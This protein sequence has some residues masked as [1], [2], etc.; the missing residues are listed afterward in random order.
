[1]RYAILLAAVCIVACTVEMKAYR[2]FADVTPVTYRVDAAPY[3]PEELEVRLLEDSAWVAPIHGWLVRQA[4]TF[5]RA[6][7]DRWIA[8]VDSQRIA[9]EK[10]L[11]LSL[12]GRGDCRAT[13]ATPV[14]S[15][16]A[17]EFAFICSN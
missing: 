11:L 9:Y 2:P 10:A 8:T 6:P 3:G 7:T 14:P 12:E 1:M 13:A 17:F 16:F 5:S 4:M 15:Y